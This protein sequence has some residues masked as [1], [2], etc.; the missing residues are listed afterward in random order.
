MQLC[1]L[2]LAHNHPDHLLR[3][4]ER[5]TSDTTSFYIH[6]DFKSPDKEKFNLLFAD[7]KNVTLISEYEVN[8]MGMNM[9]RST[10]LLYRRA[11][12]S[13]VD[14]KYFILLSGLDYPIKSKAYIHDFFEKN[15]CDFLSC[16]LVERLPE[17]FAMKS[18]VFHY[19][20]FPYTN[21]RSPRRI[22]WAVRAYYYAVRLQK[23]CGVRRRFYKNMTPCFGSQWTALT[24]ET[25]R[26]ILDFVDREPGYV[27]FMNLTEGP[28][29]TFFQTI[30]Y[31]SARSKNI[32]DYDEYQKW[33]A[34]SG[35]IQYETK[36]ANLVFMDWSERGKP[37]PAVLD[38][39]YR[40]DLKNS[41]LLFAR[42][43]DP[44]QSAS[45]LNWIDEVLL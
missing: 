29:E 39:S 37:K 12:E 30:I 8:W 19:Y 31:N 11:M 26:T 15:S 16:R 25:V 14:F 42:K 27:K 44:M 10:L 18:A 40:E 13:Q 35:K 38:D 41:P 17:S 7:K 4:Y 36:I 43:F 22:K 23:I 1:Y 2:I 9:V 32:V 24:Y 45:L 5:L 20:D 28:D 21:P 34:G 3:Q 6:I 33:M